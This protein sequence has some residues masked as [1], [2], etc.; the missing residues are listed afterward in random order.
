M[1]LNG[2]PDN[3]DK[4]PVASGQTQMLDVVP[5]PRLLQGGDTAVP[6]SR[7]SRAR[8]TWTFGRKHSSSQQE[9]EEEE[10]EETEEEKKKRKDRLIQGIR[11]LGRM[12][13]TKVR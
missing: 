6:F 1:R 5:D 4:P 11:G 12:I 7:G 9:E 2:F 3:S 8:S 13:A 10:V